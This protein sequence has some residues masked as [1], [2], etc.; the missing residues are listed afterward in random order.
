[1]IGFILNITAVALFIIITPINWLICLIKY[2]IHNDYFRSEAFD[3]DVFG[4]HNFRATFNL[5]LMKKGGYRFGKRNESISAALGHNLVL[6]RLT[7]LG[8]LV[9]IN[10]GRNHCLEAANE[11]EVYISIQEK[12]IRIIIIIAE[13]LII[14]NFFYL[15]LN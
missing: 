10:L 2:G 8:W 11:P 9:V 5:L 14:Y 7:V 15:I 12:I 1:M 3:L 13:L 6:R 4:N